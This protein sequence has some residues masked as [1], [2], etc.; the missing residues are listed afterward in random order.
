MVER[1]GK[2]HTGDDRSENVTSCQGGCSES[3]PWP[4][5]HWE[6]ARPHRPRFH[7][8]RDNSSEK[9][10]SERRGRLHVVESSGKVPDAWEPTFLAAKGVSSGRLRRSM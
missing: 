2:R 6:P 5:A 7:A 1:A 3:S 9:P 8:G 10:W 4:P